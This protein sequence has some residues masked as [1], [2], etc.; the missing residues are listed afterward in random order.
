MLA[1]VPG[2]HRRH[3]SS[4]FRIFCV[5]VA[6]AAGAVAVEGLSPGGAHAAEPSPRTTSDVTLARSALAAMDADPQL[7]DVNLVVSVVDR[8]AVI[9]GP[10]PTAEVGRRAEWLIGRIP[11]IAEVKNRCF[12]QAGPDPLIRAFADRVPAPRRP[13]F[14]D[15][16]GLVPGAKPTA[17]EESATDSF[18]GG[19]ALAA[20]AEK[21]VRVARR[22]ANPIDNILL[23]PVG[24]PGSAA[25][26]P[27]PAVRSSPT[28]S[29]TL[30]SVPPVPA[31]ATVPGKPVDVLTAAEHIR[32][33]DYRYA[34]LFVELRSGTLVI[35][36][37][38][39]RAADA[40]DLAQQLRQIP[41]I[42]RVAL[43]AIE[44]K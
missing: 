19:L 40:W 7:R 41:G 3:G 25:S 36:G 32:R 1:H 34:R 31:T 8:V 4:T 22:P 27:P 5:L 18:E 13:F 38:A 16:P 44:V 6:V 23:G 33:A 15:L 11:G 30:A 43:G 35:A 21:S 29:A 37:A 17:S 2:P 39:D 24:M 12:V 28:A 10:V 14:S 26:S 9:G 42:E 20:P